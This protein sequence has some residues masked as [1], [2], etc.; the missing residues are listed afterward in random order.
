[1]TI[2]VAPMLVIYAILNKKVIEGMV[3]GAV[4]G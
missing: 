1:M 3:A 2:S 4:K